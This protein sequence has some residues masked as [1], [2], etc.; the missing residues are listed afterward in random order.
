MTD[1][2]QQLLDFSRPFD[3]SL[4]DA[5][6]NVFY[7]AVDMTQVLM[8]ARLPARLS[9]FTFLQQWRFNPLTC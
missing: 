6:V 1:P 2:A 7:S 3:V 5:T 8:P 4:L 9:S